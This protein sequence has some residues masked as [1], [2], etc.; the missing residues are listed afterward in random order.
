MPQKTWPYCD[1]HSV[2]KICASKA[3]LDIKTNL[4]STGKCLEKSC[5]TIQFTGKITLQ[6]KSRQSIHTKSIAF[7]YLP[8]VSMTVYEEY[9]IYDFS[10]MLGSIG[11]TLGMC[12]GFSFVGMC[13]FILI[14]IQKLINYSINRNVKTDN[15]VIPDE[16]EAKLASMELQLIRRIEK[17][18]DQTVY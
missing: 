13:S 2:E 15:E 14:Q 1:F 18:K 11:G 7:Y 3:S 8:P 17:L 5:S 10:R 4:I 9:L 12:I 16:I 6:E